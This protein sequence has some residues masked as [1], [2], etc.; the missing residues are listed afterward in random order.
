MV[1]I[2]P[3]RQR[4]TN[5][6]GDRH[7]VRGALLH[8][9]IALS[10]SLSWICG[11]WRGEKVDRRWNENGR[12]QKKRWVGKSLSERTQFPREDEWVK[13]RQTDRQTDR[14]GGEKPSNQD[15]GSKNVTKTQ[16]TAFPDCSEGRG[17]SSTEE[18][19]R[20]VE[21]SLTFAFSWVL[22]FMS[23]AKKP[24]DSRCN[25]LCAYYRS[26]FCFRARQPR[27][28]GRFWTNKRAQQ[29]LSVH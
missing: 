28:L 20:R 6:K 23:E 1:P 3:H 15:E 13:C 7:Q 10:L 9:M 12:G 4:C 16:Y 14:G 25:L 29:K 18:R 24:E 17:R 2:S 26:R 27:H 19:M 5:L 8:P 22:R 11:W 21:V